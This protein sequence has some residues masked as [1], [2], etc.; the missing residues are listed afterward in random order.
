MNH[1]MQKWATFITTILLILRDHKWDLKV[2]D[3]GILIHLLCFVTLSSCSLSWLFKQCF[4]GWTL[5]PSLGKT[6]LKWAQTEVLISLDTR[7]NTGQDIYIYLMFVLECGD[8][9]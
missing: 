5:F 8:D 1:R 9:L 2:C 3:D 6:S 7:T 4:R